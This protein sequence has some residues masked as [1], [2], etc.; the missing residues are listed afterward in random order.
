MVRTASFIKGICLLTCLALLAGSA[1]AADFFFKDGDVIVVMGDSITEQHLYSNYLEMQE[2]LRQ[3][4]APRPHSVEVV[5]A[6][7]AK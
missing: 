1:K 3:A 5:P 4:L 2:A 6:Q 7:P